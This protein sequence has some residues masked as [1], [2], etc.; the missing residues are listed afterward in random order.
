ML[1]RTHARA[2]T[3]CLLSVALLA[4]ASFAQIGPVPICQRIPNGNFVNGFN[5]WTLDPCVNGFGDW[6]GSA[7]ATIEDLTS[8]GCDAHVA[9]L[10]NFV[11]VNWTCDKP[12]GAAAQAQMSIS[13]EAVVTGRYLE[14]KVVGGFEFFAWA[15]ADVKYN[16]L[17][18]VTNQDGD[19]VKCDILEGDFDA[20]YPCD[21]G[22][23][24]LGAIPLETVCCDLQAGGIMVGDTVTIEVIW[25]ATVIACNDCDM[26]T[27]FGSFCVDEFRF[28]KACLNP[29]QL[30]FEVDPVL[31]PTTAS[32]LGLGDGQ[33]TAIRRLHRTQDVLG[34]DLG[35]AKRDDEIEIR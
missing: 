8:I 20:D 21:T 28:C 23:Q 2:V 31:V 3:S 35:T 6:S 22:I 13:T 30:P 9:C 25:S 4:S 1:N 15:E 12:S 19:Q 7:N 11:D 26:A 10:N 29:A 14:F 32:P 5:G 18:V 24:A 17:V 16:A 34:I 33:D 27:F